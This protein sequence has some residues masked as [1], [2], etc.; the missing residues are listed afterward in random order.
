MP[1]EIQ[2]PL[3]LFSLLIVPCRFDGF[4]WVDT[5]FVSLLYCNSSSYFFSTFFGLTIL[6]LL[7]FYPL[8]FSSWNLIWG[9]LK[10]LNSS[11][12]AVSVCLVLAQRFT[13]NIYII[14]MGCMSFISEVSRD[15]INTRDTEHKDYKTY[16]WESV[17]IFLHTINFTGF[18]F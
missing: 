13:S 3:S 16:S 4:V 5:E 1:E 6:L 7:L 12:S 9:I 18:Y 2:T 14:V 10:H 15:S 8:C 11:L 17:I